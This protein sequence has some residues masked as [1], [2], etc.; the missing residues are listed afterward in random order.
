MPKKRKKDGIERLVELFVK[1]P[2]WLPCVLAVAAFYAV[3]VIG[4]ILGADERWRVALEAWGWLGFAVFAVCGVLSWFERAR[5]ERLIAASAKLEHVRKLSWREFEELC[6]EAYRRKGYKVQ[7]TAAGADG[8]VDL[9]LRNGRERI[10][11][12]CKHYREWKVGVRPV[13]ELFGVMAA[14]GA[15]AGVL[16]TSGKFTN[17]AVAFARGK[18]L[19]LVD[20]QG[21]LRLIRDVRHVN[22]RLS[23]GDASP[24]SKPAAQTP[25]PGRSSRQRPE[26]AGQPWTPEESREL[27]LLAEAGASLAQLAARHARTPHAIQLQL[28][29]LRARGVPAVADEP[30]R[31]RV[32][33]S[34]QAKGRSLTEAAARPERSRRG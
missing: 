28:D 18:R 2:W 6:A 34:A 9:V 24:S 4:T 23:P 13:R 7:E 3:P 27:L 32:G 20:G 21:L 5:R 11:V 29:R 10:F 31:G 30:E 33:P 26:R 14:E 25:P 8:G 15:D 1:A 22:S 19:T 12:Q 16:V 17:D